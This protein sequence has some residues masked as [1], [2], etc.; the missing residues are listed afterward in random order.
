MG[1]KPQSPLELHLGGSNMNTK[2]FSIAGFGCGQLHSNSPACDQGDVNIWHR[3]GG[4]QY[5]HGKRWQ[6]TPELERKK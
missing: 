4:S 1:Q 5:F 2:V 6:D 3:F